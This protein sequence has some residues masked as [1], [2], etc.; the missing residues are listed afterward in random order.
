MPQSRSYS[1]QLIRVV[2]IF[3]NKEML[4]KQQDAFTDKVCR[5]MKLKIVQLY[6]NL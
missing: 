1:R 3:F 5:A 2:D 4:P 6:T